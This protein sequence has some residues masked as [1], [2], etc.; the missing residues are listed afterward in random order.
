MAYQPHPRPDSKTAFGELSVSEPTTVTALQF[1]YNINSR[2]IDR[3]ENNLGTVTQS[4]SMAIIQSGASA[5]SAGCMLSRLPLQYIP[6]QGASVRLTALFTP[7]VVNSFQLIGIGDVGDGLFF[8]FNGNEFSIL[9]RELGHPEVQTL[10]ITTGA[11]T[12]TGNVTIN[13]DGVSK[14]VAVTNGDSAREV[15]VKI[16]NADFSDTGLGWSAFVNNATIIFIA[17]SDGNKVGTFSLV[18]TATTG[19]VGAFAETVTGSTTID[20]WTAQTNWNVDSFNG[21]GASGVVLDPTK[22]NVYQIRYQWLGFGL[23][24][25]SIEDPEDGDYHEVHRIKYANANVVPSFQNPTLPLFAIT[26]NIAN[27]SNLVIKT[28]SM[29]GAVEGKQIFPSAVLN[30]QNAFSIVVGATE[31]PILSIKNNIVYQNVKNRV[32]MIPTLLSLATDASN[33]VIFRVRLNTTLTGTPAFVDLD[34]NSSVVSTDTSATG[35]ID[36]SVVITEVLTKADS[37]S[38]DLSAIADQSQQAKQVRPGDSL[39]IT[40]Q[41]VAGANHTALVS[42]NWEELF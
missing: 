25:F 35:F 37:K 6:G 26:Q 3:R 38:V 29:A 9:R 39:T 1:P 27:T 12:A 20:N 19:T 30:S 33:S 28:S 4:Q 8:G 16:A 15:A 7:G 32:G 10:T 5:N 34:S 22:G 2:L 14:T 24:T 23:L 41:A 13:L 31:I 17:W 40:A 42:I 18:D 21:T 11:V 36:G